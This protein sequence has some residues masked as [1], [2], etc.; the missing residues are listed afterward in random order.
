MTA[1]EKQ[2]QDA[3]PLW[4]DEGQ[5]LWF[6][7]QQREGC[8]PLAAAEIAERLKFQPTTVVYRLRE[9]EREGRCAIIR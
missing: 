8:E 3:N 7:D 4:T 2:E 5:I 1:A 9:L 6:L